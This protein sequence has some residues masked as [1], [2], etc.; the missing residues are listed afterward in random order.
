[1]IRR[2]SPPCSPLHSGEGQASDN[3]AT[4]SS[5]GAAETGGSFTEDDTD[6]NTFQRR[7]KLLA[8]QSLMQPGSS[9]KKRASLFQNG[10]TQSGV[11]NQSALRA[12]TAAAVKANASIY[13]STSAGLQA[14]PPGGQ[15]AKRQLARAIG[16]LTGASI[17]NDLNGNA[18]S[19]D[20]LATL[21]AD[22]GGKAFFD[23]TISAASSPRCRRSSVYYVLGFT[24]TIRQKTAGSGI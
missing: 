4:G 20:T 9:R 16:L 10:I 19:Q 18:A 23:S 6:L 2:S 3:G 17:M 22:T 7:F 12:A 24:A 5:E 21:S 14:F 13:S 15:G 1:M 11:D 8:I